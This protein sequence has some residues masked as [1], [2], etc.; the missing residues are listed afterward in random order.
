MVKTKDPRSF[1]GLCL[2]RD[3]RIVWLR[4]RLTRK[5]V[6][7]YLASLAAGLLILVLA[8]YDFVPT[9]EAGADAISVQ[10]VGES[11]EDN[12]NTK[13]ATSTN[14]FVTRTV[15]GDTLQVI[16]DGEKDAIT[17]RLLGVNTPETVDP[18]RPVECFGKEA[19]NF[20]KDKT[21]GKRIRLVDDP[22]ADEIDKYGRL[23]RN[24]VLEDGMDFNAELVLQG[25]ANA[26]VSFPLAIERKAQLLRLEAEAREAKRG[27]WNPEVCP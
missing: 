24:V 5:H 17:V 16:L 2:E 23:L 9:S 12:L 25:Y 15:D 18:R 3:F 8:Q 11:V 22:E 10:A 1:E 19:S 27:L 21:Q 13:T 20:A 6:W 14:A 26:Y 7:S 4:M